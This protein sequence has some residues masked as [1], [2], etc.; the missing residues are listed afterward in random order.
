[1]LS[2]DGAQHAR[3]RAPFT[4]PF[5]SDEIHARL[6]SFIRAEA[7]RLVSAIEPRGAAELRRAVAGPLAAAV[8]AEALGLGQAD[9]ARILAWYDGIVAAVQAEAAAAEARPGR[10]RGGPAGSAAF[11]ELAASLREVIAAA[12]GS[13]LLA[14][15]TRR[16]PD[17]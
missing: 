2:L 17:R 9:P 14:G 7:G 10:S 1:M 8:M 11:A 4:A 6:G 13:S 15:V 3:H 16:R 12:P 5:R